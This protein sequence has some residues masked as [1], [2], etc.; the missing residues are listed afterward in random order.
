MG[1]L[2]DVPVETVFVSCYSKREDSREPQRH[3]LGP[4]WMAKPFTKPDG[5]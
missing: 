3:R 5:R 1:M 4:L 2:A